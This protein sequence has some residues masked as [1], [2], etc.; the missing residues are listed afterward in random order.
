MDEEEKCAYI[1]NIFG[2][3]DLDGNGTI[4]IRELES[5]IMN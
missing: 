4:D 3:L 1:D 5:F 2:M